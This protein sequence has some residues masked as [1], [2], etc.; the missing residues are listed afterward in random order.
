MSPFWVNE[1]PYETLRQ[2]YCLHVMMIWIGNTIP[3]RT[4]GLKAISYRLHHE[5]RLFLAHIRQ[6]PSRDGLD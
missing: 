3:F 6:E 5:V 4:G 2:S 1:L